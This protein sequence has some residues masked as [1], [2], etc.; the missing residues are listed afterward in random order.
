MDQRVEEEGGESNVAVDW[1]ELDVDSEGGRTRFESVDGPTLGYFSSVSYHVKTS[2][3]KNEGQVR[4]FPVFVLPGTGSTR[5]D[6]PVTTLT[7]MTTPDSSWIQH[8]IRISS[9]LP[10]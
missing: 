7:S 10:L 9:M 2:L 5:T 8:N 3:P 4:I 6:T 1:L